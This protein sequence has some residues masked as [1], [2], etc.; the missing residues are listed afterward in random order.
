MLLRV[1]GLAKSYG[2]FNVLQSIN[3]VIN[4]G[5]RVGLVGPNG[6]G[7]STLLRIVMGQEEADAGSFTYGPGLEAGY[8]AQST[9]A[10]YGRSMQDLILEAVG[11]VRQLEEEM[12]DLESALGDPANE[13]QLA[14]LLE[15]YGQVLA[16]FQELSR[17]L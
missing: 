3:F 8:L 15:T 11:H 6:V 7:K 9:P 1:R 12:R 14:D 5:D 10:F 2:A 17:L 13:G 16:R 4:A